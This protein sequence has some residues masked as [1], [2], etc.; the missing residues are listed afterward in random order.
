MP[1]IKTFVGLES[2]RYIST[3]G[4]CHLDHSSI[5]TVLPHCPQ[6]LC[7]VFEKFAQDLHVTIPKQISIQSLK[8]S[9]FFRPELCALDK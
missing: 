7:S 6:N 3:H 2:N 9:R 4:H 5:M 8:Q 1:I